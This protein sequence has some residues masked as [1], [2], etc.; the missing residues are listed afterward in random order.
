VGNR[1]F[2]GN[3]QRRKR[4]FLIFHG[5]FLLNFDLQLIAKYLCRPSSR[6]IARN[7]RTS[8]F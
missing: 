3:A 6:I 5:T 4:D 8:I 1:K 7:V 2:S